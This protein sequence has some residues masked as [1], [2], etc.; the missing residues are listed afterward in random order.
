MNIEEI[1]L[2]DGFD[3]H[4]DQKEKD[5]I[6]RIVPQ[7]QARIHLAFRAHLRISNQV[8]ENSV[9]ALSEHMVTICVR[10]SRI[11]GTV[12][13][14]KTSFHLFDIIR[15]VTISDTTVIIDH[16]NFSVLI[17]SSICMRFARSLIRNF[18]LAAPNLPGQMRFQFIC[19]NPKYFPYF[20]PSLSPSQ[21]FQ[22]SYNSYCSYYNTTYY[23]EIPQYFHSLVTSGNGIF[24][25]SQLPTYLLE[26]GLGINADLRPVA[27][28]IMFNPFVY[29]FVC[30]DFARPDIVSISASILISNPNVKIIRLVNTNSQRG[31]FEV[32]KAI[33][34]FIYSD[35][36]YWDFSYNHLQDIGEFTIALQQYQ[37]QVESIKLDFCQLQDICIESLFDSI[38]LNKNLHGLIQLSIMGNTIRKEN[39]VLY[40]KMLRKLIRASNKLKTLRFGPIDMVRYALNPFIGKNSKLQSITF[41]KCSFVE[42]DGEI[43]VKAISNMS[44]LVELEIFDC[45]I[46]I[47]HLESVLSVISNNPLC[48]SFK[49]HLNTMGIHGSYLTS[50]LTMLSSLSSKL[51]SLSLNN[52]GMGVNDLRNLV[53]SLKDYQ[54]LNEL[55]LSGNFSYKLTGIASALTEILELTQVHNIK[56]SGSQTKKLKNE[57]ASFI[58]GLYTCNHINSLDISGNSIG[59][60]LLSC[61]QNLIRVN[62][63]LQNI[64]LDGSSC[65]SFDVFES[66]IN[67]ASKSMALTHFPFPI[68]DAYE[69]LSSSKSDLSKLTNTITALQTSLQ[70]SLLKNRSQLGIHSD[71]TFLND[72]VLNS[73]IDTSTFEVNER[74]IGM[75]VHEHSKITQIVGLPLPFD[76]E[77][78]P[79]INDEQEKNN[80]SEHDDP[81]EAYTN[82]SNFDPVRDSAVEDSLKTLQF[83]SLCLRRPHF[84]QVLQTKSSLPSIPESVSTFDPSSLKP[85]DDDEVQSN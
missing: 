66:L 45:K 54:N 73:I 37:A 29:G 69:L 61:I 40:G 30:S 62:P 18:I 46:G 59:D 44:K 35:V 51:T 6:M 27:S 49:L 83:N 48:I 41:Y 70:R 52:N 14:F 76:N 2:D 74:L 68:K 31:C 67:F 3:Y 32:A 13:K 82:S 28:A 9:V 77:E 57:A 72:E 64:V 33:Q 12:L 17:S 39:S 7:H 81:N 55:S 75:P 1:K 4:L 15:F 20:N 53:G 5:K 34:K 11:I 21:M 26:C 24:D 36:R 71:L 65:S 50:L 10:S 63:S 85:Q 8:H 23:H 42:E 58:C 47:S 38:I 25:V 22:F 56:I 16:K 79:E 60:T 84:V 78:P 43:L 80:I 19:H